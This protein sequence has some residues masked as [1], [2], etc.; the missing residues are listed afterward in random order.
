MALGDRR[1]ALLHE[2][3]TEPEPTP[4]ALAQR[5]AG[6][7][8]VLFEGFRNA[9]IPMIEVFRPSLGRPMLWPNCPSVVAIAADGEVS[10]PHPVLDLGA[11]QAVATFVTALL[12]LRP[13]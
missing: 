5:M 12:G 2:Y 10:C 3:D 11:P 4:L 1:W 13:K 6:V 7:D 9:P 8:I